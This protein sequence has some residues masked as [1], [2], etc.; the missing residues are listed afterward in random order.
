MV[1]ASLPRPH[2]QADHAYYDLGNVPQTKVSHTFTFTNDG[3][4]DLA[5]KRIWTSCGCTTAKLILNGIESPEFGMPGHGGSVGPWEAKLRPGETASLKVFYDAPSMPDIYVGER[6]V[7]VDSDDPT[8]P[9]YQF[10]IA[11]QEVP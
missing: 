4:A 7:Y 2:I 6:Y 10:T 3:G 1:M 11:V 5:I 9:E 8:Q